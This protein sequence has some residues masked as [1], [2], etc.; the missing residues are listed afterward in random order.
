MIETF[1]AQVWT[2]SNATVTDDINLSIDGSSKKMVFS[3][4]NGYVNVAFTPV[5][6]SKWEEIGCYLYIGKEVGVSGELLKI[7]VGGNDYTIDTEQIGN[8]K[9]NGFNFLLID[10][11]VLSTISS[12]RFTSLIADLTIYVDYLFHRQV[13]YDT[14]DSDIG[15][16]LEDEISLDYGVAT[17]LSASCVAGDTLVSLASMVYLFENTQLIIDEGLGTE[18]EVVLAD[19]EG[20]LLEVLKYSHSAGAVVTA[21]CPVV[22]GKFDTIEYNP[23]VGIVVKGRSA[24]QDFFV[25][26]ML[27]GRKLK[28]HLGEL[29][30]TI[31]IECTSEIKAL[32]L[33]RQFDD[34]YGD[35][36]KFMLDGEFVDAY[37]EN[38]LYVGSELGGLVRI[39]YD[40]TLVPQAVSNIVGVPIDTLT[41]NL[42]SNSV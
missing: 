12:L 40:Y 11:T 3:A 24:A 29:S 19:K 42:E 28:K 31:Y 26:Q 9:A 38:S 32:S 25:S 18:E 4:I 7:T 37:L 17:T 27:G 8:I 10:S 33:A 2:A 23:V 1:L 16:A 13:T 34:K 41:L 30:L 36:F 6:V 21:L 39:T 20:N 5:D 22:F 14:M 35:S 15:E